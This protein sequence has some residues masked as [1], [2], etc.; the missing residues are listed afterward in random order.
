MGIEGI[1]IYW[2]TI[3][4]H[5][6]IYSKILV[7]KYKYQSTDTMKEDSLKDLILNW[8]PFF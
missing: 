8:T 3:V 5:G 4:I 6:L 7:Y 2:L 1:I